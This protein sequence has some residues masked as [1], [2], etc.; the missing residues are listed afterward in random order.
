MIDRQRPGSPEDGTAV[1]VVGS[2]NVD[3]VLSLPR[4]PAPGETVIGGRLQGA[5]GGKGGN[6]AVAAARLGARTWLVGCIGDDDFG[7]EAREDLREAGVDTRLLGTGRAPT[8]VAVVM[9]DA[10]GENAIAVASGANQELD[11]D[12]VRAAC[13]SIPSRDAVVLACLEVPDA[14]VLAAAEAAAAR[15]WPF[16]LNP[17]PA[18][19]LARELL[20]RC[21]V[22]TPN[23]HEV[24]ALGPSSISDL[25]AGGVEAVVVTRGSQG[26]DLYRPDQPVLH[27][28][29]FA[30][31]VLDTTGA[32]D[33]F[34][35]ALAWALAGGQSLEEAVRVAAA[36]GALSTQAV[37]ARTSLPDRMALDRLLASGRPVR[38]VR[39]LGR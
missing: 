20:R 23:H 29:P 9:V 7:R 30:V 22:L 28:P 14:A 33:A 5:P 11:P 12:M 24:T 31:S 26:A 6:Q 2:V 34:S 16:V 13:A 10:A 18:R 25:L 21:A 15:G 36:A 27:Q 3:L 39:D 17:A 38:S 4:L 35:A 37:G 32:G 8:G 19:P 1:V